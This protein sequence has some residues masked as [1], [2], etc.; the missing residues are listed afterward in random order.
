MSPFGGLNESPGLTFKRESLILILGDAAESATSSSTRRPVG[1]L[2]CG[3]QSQP[4]EGYHWEPPSKGSHQTSTL[5]ASERWN[6]SIAFVALLA[7][8]IGAM[9]F[10]RPLCEMGPYSCRVPT[11]S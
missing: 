1:R 6:A 8:L 10:Y 7:L 9:T 4:A 11:A 2:R 5:A 3:R